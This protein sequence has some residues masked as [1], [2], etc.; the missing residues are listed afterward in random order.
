MRI[1]QRF[2]AVLLI[3]VIAAV[4]ITMSGLGGRL[5]GNSGSADS[6]LTVVRGYGGELKVNFMNDPDVAAILAERYGL[7]VDIT[8]AGSI[9]M[10]CDLPLE[11]M[12]FIWAGD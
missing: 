5:F 6:D 10:L 9:E 1:Q 4:G 8:K 12:D 7:D 3:A 11:E 2:G